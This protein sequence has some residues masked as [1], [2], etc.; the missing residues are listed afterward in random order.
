MSNLGVVSDNID[1]RKQ[2]SLAQYDDKRFKVKPCNPRKVELKR[3]LQLFMILMA[4]E[5]VR[6]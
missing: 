3:K 2:F 6:I 4:L 1:L 5:R